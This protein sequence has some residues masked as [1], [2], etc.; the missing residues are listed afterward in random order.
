MKKSFNL[1]PYIL[2]FP[3]LMA[4]KSTIENK[5]LPNVIDKQMDKR[6]NAFNIL[7]D[8]NNITAVTVGSGTPFSLD[9]SMT[10]TAIF[11]NQ[12]FFMFD[13]GPGVVAQIE[14]QNLPITEIDGIFLT[15]YHSDHYMDLPNLVNRS[16]SQGKAEVMNIYGPDGLKGLVEGLNQFLEIENQYRVDHHGAE[17]LNI[18]NSRPITHEFQ[19]DAH[20]KK[21][22]FN[23]DG[24]KITAF[25]VNHDPVHSAVGYAIEYKDKKVVLSGDTKKNDLL[26]EMAMGADLLIHE[27]M[28]KSL[29]Q[30]MEGVAQKRGEQRN[31]QVFQDIQEYHTSPSEVA[32]TA[33]NANVKKLVLNHMAPTADNAI[34]KSMYKNQMKEYKGELVFSND[35]D[36]FIIK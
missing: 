31:A 25:K 5:V 23:Q 15:H 32:E 6:L 10:G 28:L 14:L 30:K 22:V 4:C 34:L 19:L 26:Q 12:H 9:R 13:V 27:V 16:W 36:M 1:L 18:H 21:V 20:D 33:K 3:L 29:I 8:T 7:K 11:V 24:V 35:G 17:M 2:A